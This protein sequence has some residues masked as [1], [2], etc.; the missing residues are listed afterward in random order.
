[1]VCRLRHLRIVATAIAIL[2]AMAVGDSLAPYVELVSNLLARLCS[3]TSIRSTCAERDGTVRAAERTQT[4]AAAAGDHESRESI[5]LHVRVL[6]TAG[7]P[8][9]NA[10]VRV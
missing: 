10:T 6:D 1:M 5:R 2:C 7:Q 9:P 8:V 3:P 4:N